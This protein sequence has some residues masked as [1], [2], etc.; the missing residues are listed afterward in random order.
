MIFLCTTPGISKIQ[1]KIKIS[2]LK[3]YLPLIALI[4]I[5]VQLFGLIETKYELSFIIRTVKVFSHD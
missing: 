1:V 3:S 4:G 5:E 2:S